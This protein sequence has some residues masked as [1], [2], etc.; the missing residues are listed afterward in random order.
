LAGWAR[1]L[2]T[3]P[4]PERAPDPHGDEAAD[5]ARA[6]LTDTVAF[7]ELS[8]FGERIRTSNRFR[9]AFESAGR[10]LTEFGPLGA[11]AA[12]LSGDSTQP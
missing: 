9:N 10:Q 7:L 11:I 1:Y 5:L 6:A 4:A 3:V 8:I 2:A 12:L